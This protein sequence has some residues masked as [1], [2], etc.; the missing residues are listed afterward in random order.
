MR[1][2]LCPNSILHDFIKR[3]KDELSESRDAF[4]KLNIKLENE[5]T[6]LSNN[7]KTVV[8]EMKKL[9]SENDIFKQK[10]SELQDE[11]G[12]LKR[13]K[14]SANDKVKSRDEEIERLEVENSS[15]DEQL[16]GMKAENNEFKEENMKI[17]KKIDDLE[18]ENEKLKD[19]LYGCPECGLN[20]CECSGVENEDNYPSSLP[21]EFFSQLSSTQN[22]PQPFSDTFPSLPWTPPP[23]PPCVSCGG[24]NFGPSPSSLCFKCIPPLK[25]QHQPTTSVSPS[26][27]PPGTPPPKT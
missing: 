3:L 17:V 11:I 23:T 18:K 5:N 8:E 12:T 9:R 2:L 19:V 21:T 10:N 15:L 22:P 16:K 13:E 20:S 4:S 6:V 14:N 24:V 7:S 1:A 26:R 27:T 25:C